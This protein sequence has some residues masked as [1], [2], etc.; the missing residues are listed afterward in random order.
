MVSEE[1]CYNPRDTNSCLI[2]TGKVYITRAAV[3]NA[4]WNYYQCIVP[5]KDVIAALHNAGILEEDNSGSKTKK[6]KYGGRHYVISV[7]MLQRYC[8]FKNGKG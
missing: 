3:Q 1:A 8:D 7:K 6:C 4:V 5:V 2:W